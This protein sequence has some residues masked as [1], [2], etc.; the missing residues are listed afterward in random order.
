MKKQIII[1]TLIMATLAAYSLY[2]SDAL[3]TERKTF[4]ADCE[5][6]NGIYAEGVLSKM[7][8]RHAGCKTK[9]CD[10]DK[11]GQGEYVLTFTRHD[12]VKPTVATLPGIKE[13]LDAP[14]RKLE[15]GKSYSVCMK[16]D[17]VLIDYY[18]SF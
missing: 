11:G 18:K 6:N 17:H 10:P 8:W 9:K 12:L 7:E 13:E 3:T 1:G 2:N 16:K 14:R 15:H 5:T 4:V